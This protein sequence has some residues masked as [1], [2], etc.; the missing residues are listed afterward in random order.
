VRNSHDHLLPSPSASFGTNGLD[1]KP[2]L[3]FMPSGPNMKSFP[4]SHQITF[5]HARPVLTPLTRKMMNPSQNLTQM[6]SPRQNLTQMMSL[7]QSLGM[8]FALN[9]RTS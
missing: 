1:I 3:T 6:L 9:Q 2:I 8:I 7:T 5:P 4:C